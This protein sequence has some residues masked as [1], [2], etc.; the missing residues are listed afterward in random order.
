MSQLV[1]PDTLH[2]T[3]KVMMDSAIVGSAQAAMDRLLGL[4]LH[5]DLDPRVATSPTRQAALLTVINCARR[6]FLGGVTVSGC[7]GIP[8]TVPMPG[9]DDLSAAIEFWGGRRVGQAPPGVI[10]IELGPRSSGGSAAVFRPTFEGWTGAVL[11]IQ[12]SSRLPESSENVLSGVF[13]GAMAVAEAFQCAT[14]TNVFA[15]R[16]DVGLSL[17]DLDPETDWRQAPAG[18]PLEYLPSS[19]WL[20]GL[21]HLGQAYLWTLGLL[22]FAKASEV[23]L[24]LQDFDQL[25]IANDSTSPLTK[26]DLIGVRKTRAM[27][28]WCE[29]RGFD[30]RLIE[31]PFSSDLRI[32][33]DDPRV[34]L[35]GVDKPEPRA[36]MEDVGFDVVVEAGLGKGWQDYLDGQVHSFP[37]QI[38]AAEHW[39]RRIPMATLVPPVPSYVQLSAAG[40]DACGVLELASRSVG[41]AFVGCASA[42][43]V[44]AELVRLLHGGPRHALVDWSLRDLSQRR[45]FLA[46]RG[47]PIPRY[48]LAHVPS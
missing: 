31:R 20:I 48:T 9:C 24:M 28:A 1:T 47:S 13:M 29:R 30:V 5:V 17:W 21:G 37:S 22:P 38:S 3:A 44:L 12:G 35:V 4:A 6:C 33:G 10:A 7:D 26:T 45:V 14:H 19:L 25:V 40:L 41:A 39:G 36:C 43:I 34:A 15:G 11:G 2:R 8:L 16:R 27:A 42:A 32:G 23:Q 18:P 46:S